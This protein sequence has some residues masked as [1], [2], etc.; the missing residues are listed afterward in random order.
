MAGHAR[1]Y[2]WGLQLA[3]ASVSDGSYHPV[4]LYYYLPVAV[5]LSAVR[6]LNPAVLSIRLLTWQLCQQ[7]PSTVYQQAH[8]MTWRELA[9][10][11]G[12]LAG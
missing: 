3:P 6:P 12:P 11:P 5:G 9:V 2:A 8:E 7:H 10:S 4:L 1:D